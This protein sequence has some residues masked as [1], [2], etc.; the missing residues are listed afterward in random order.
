MQPRID[1]G[2]SRL[3]CW[4]FSND[5]HASALCPVHVG[6]LCLT[7]LDKHGDPE[8]EF[9]RN[10]GEPNHFI[11]VHWSLACRFVK[12]LKHLRDILSRSF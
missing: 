7:R 3:L 12:P 1:P 10:D 5:L 2:S 4:K 11:I 8:L 9:P 6:L